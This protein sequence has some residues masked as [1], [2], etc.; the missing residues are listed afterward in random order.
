MSV[1]IGPK[2]AFIAEKAL[3]DQHA[4]VSGRESFRRACE[5]T[6]LELVWTLPDRNDPVGAAANWQMIVGARSALRL[7]SS[8]AD[9]AKPPDKPVTYNLD[10]QA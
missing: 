9:P 10:H 8:I 3:S 2:A 5:A 1:M 7:L 4:E 6:L